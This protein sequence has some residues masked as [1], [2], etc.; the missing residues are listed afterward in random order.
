MCRSIRQKLV[1]IGQAAFL[2]IE[3]SNRARAGSTSLYLAL[4][5]FSVLD[6][7]FIMPFS[8]ALNLMFIF[9][10]YFLGVELPIAW[11]VVED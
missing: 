8:G 5:T 1:A 10:V 4:E 3:T 7:F 6:F 2:D 11:Y 9:Y